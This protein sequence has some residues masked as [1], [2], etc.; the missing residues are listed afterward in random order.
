MSD[1][2][3]SD[4]RSSNSETS[5][6]ELSKN[7]LCNR[8]SEVHSA[9]SFATFGVIDSFVHPGI[10]I[11]PIG[12]LRLPLSEEDAR[13]LIQAS[14]KAPFGKGTET[15]IDGSVRKTWEIDAGKIQFLNK[16]WQRCLNRT[17]E[18]VVRELGVADGSVN[19][20]AEFYK[21]LLY[22]KGAMFK[23]HKEY[24]I[25]ETHQVIS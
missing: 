25:C 13:T 18:H 8:I 19:V 21:M 15:V 12:T 17:V 4:N 7:D 1:S 22:E 23:A 11:D 3:N 20:R 14:H 2:S 6:R 5:D 24:L 10:S 16:E 9:G